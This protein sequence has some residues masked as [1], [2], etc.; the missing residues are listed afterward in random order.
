MASW[1]CSKSTSCSRRLRASETFPMKIVIKRA[2]TAK[3]SHMPKRWGENAVVGMMDLEY[4]DWHISQKLKAETDC[5][6]ET[7]GPGPL[8]T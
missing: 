5:G 3:A 4:R 1:L 6:K 8:P 2:A 7:E